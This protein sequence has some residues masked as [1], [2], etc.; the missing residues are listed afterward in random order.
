MAARQIGNFERSHG[1]YSGRGGQCLYRRQGNDRIRRVD[2]SSNIATVAGTGVAGFSGDGGLG[3]SA[4]LNGPFAVWVDA[5][6][7]DLYI[8]DSG[9][10]RI[11]MLKPGV[12]RCPER[13]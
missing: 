4:R 6:S 13:G 1:R 5:F 7:G 3:T 8:S 12:H 11:R 9:N 2:L 10:D